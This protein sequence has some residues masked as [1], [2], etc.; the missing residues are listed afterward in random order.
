MGSCSTS[1][2]SDDI[3]TLVCLRLIMNALCTHVYVSDTHNPLAVGLHRL[4]LYWHWQYSQCIHFDHKVPYTGGRPDRRRDARMQE[5]HIGLIW[6]IATNAAIGRGLLASR[7][8]HMKT[9]EAGTRRR[10]SSSPV[11]PSRIAASLGDQDTPYRQLHIPPN[12][13]K[14]PYHALAWGYSAQGTGMRNATNLVNCV[15]LPSRTSPAIYTVTL[16]PT[17]SE[18][19]IVDGACQCGLCLSVARPTV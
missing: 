9:K 10:N 5:S 11:G 2:S 16:T 18:A 19:N 8:V 13:V 6:P 3:I 14:Q 1:E 17:A 15:P 7:L 4:A 12:M